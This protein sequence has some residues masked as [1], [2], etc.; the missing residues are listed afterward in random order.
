MGTLNR[1]VTPCKEHTSSLVL[2]WHPSSYT[3]SLRPRSCCYATQFSRSP[4]LFFGTANWIHAARA[5]Q[6]TQSCDTQ[7]SNVL[8]M[9]HFSCFSRQYS[10]VLQFPPAPLDKLATPETSQD[11]KGRHTWTA[12]ISGQSWG[13]GKY[14]V[15]VSSIWEPQYSQMWRIFDHST[16]DLD[17]PHF[18]VNHYSWTSGLF[19]GERSSKY[20]LD[21][22]YYGV[23]LRRMICY[24]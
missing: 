18:G 16:E 3:G 19:Q 21:A 2:I 22:E 5:R 20:T 10:Q 15:K 11:D 23:C 24:S 9:T 6:F 12:S 17:C 4:C 8:L 14:E 13:N 7:P 1:F